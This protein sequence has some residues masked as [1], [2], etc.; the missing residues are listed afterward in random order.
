MRI[1]I[2][3]DYE[4]FR[5]QFKKI[6]ASLGLRDVQ[7][8]FEADNGADAL[9]KLEKEKTDILFTDIKMPKNNGIDLLQQVK[10]QELCPCVIL[11]SEYAD[12]DYARR[13]LILGAFDY[14]VK[15]IEPDK[16]R[17]VWERAEAFLAQTQTQRENGENEESGRLETDAIVYCILHQGREMETLCDEAVCRFLKEPGAMVHRTLRLH[18]FLSRVHAG[19]AEA[20]PWIEA[21]VCSPDALKQRLLRSDDA[22]IVYAVAKEYLLELY[23]TVSRFYPAGMSEL[24]QKAVS[25]VLSHPGDK[26]TLTDLAEYCCVN[27]TYLSHSF[28]TDMGESFVDYVLRY[29]MQMAKLLLAYSDTPV[30]EIAFRLGYDDFKYMSKVFKSQTGFTP[31]DYR[32]NNG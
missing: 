13:G 14:L 7:I 29:K 18:A 3:D 17:A 31:S 22:M 25:Y 26:I 21:L 1:G 24:S 23:A 4:I 15:P 2:V 12:F 5:I 11:L 8:V 28:K 9:V 10:E 32:K 16:L 20:Y 27:N 19:T 30:S 6:L